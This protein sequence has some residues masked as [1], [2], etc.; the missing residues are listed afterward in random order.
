EYL[1]LPGN[2]ERFFPLLYTGFVLGGTIAVTAWR[3]V[4]PVRLPPAS[5]RLDRLAAGVLF[6]VAGFLVL[7][8]LPS[9]VDALRDSPSRVEYLSSPTPFWLVKLM[10]LGIVA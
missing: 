5:R 4:D 9:F 1:R 10:D 2:S 8:H 7:Q 3:S 6:A